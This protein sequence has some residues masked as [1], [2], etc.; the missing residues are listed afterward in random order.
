MARTLLNLEEDQQEVQQGIAVSGNNKKSQQIESIFEEFEKEFEDEEEELQ[1]LIE[2]IEEE[3]S[4]GLQYL[5]GVI[6]Y[7]VKHLF[8]EYV[9]NSTPAGV[10]TPGWVEKFEKKRTA[11]PTTEFTKMIFDMDINFRMQNKDGINKEPQILS[12]FCKNIEIKLPHIEQEIAKVFGR[13]RLQLMIKK[14]N[15]QIREE[16]KLK[17]KLNKEK[18]AQ[19]AKRKAEKASKKTP[20]RGRRSSRKVKEYT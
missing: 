1:D 9:A 16:N 13:T 14:E 6:C 18:K 10:H 4:M 19:I 17:R 11:A 12:K 8:P 5:A 2:E 3:N 15:V 7:K 20:E